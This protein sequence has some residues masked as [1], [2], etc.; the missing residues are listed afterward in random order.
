MGVGLV[1]IL[2][3]KA[4]GNTCEGAYVLE[5]LQWLRPA[6]T[7]ENAATEPSSLSSQG[8]G[9]HSYKVDTAELK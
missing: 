2:P 9:W 4:V 8:Q 5:E 6:M 1:D 3:T 7:T